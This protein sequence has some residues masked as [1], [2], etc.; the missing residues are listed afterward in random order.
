MFILDNINTINKKIVET[1]SET[2]LDVIN[3][4]PEGF[5]NNIAWNFGHIV[6][7]SY[8]LAFLATG[9]DTSIQLPY[10]EQY[11]RGSSP[12]GP[13]SQEEINELISLADNFTAEVR[14]ALDANKFSHINTYTT[15]T[16]GVPITNINDMLTTIAMHN[17]LHWQ[18]I[19][20]YK[21]ILKS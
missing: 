11:K 5:N 21:R 9:A 19:K 16:F 2:E 18:I 13:V 8:S 6:I 10:V 4:I 20:D 17:T 3:K 14:A 1:V 7:S 15:Q 12:Q